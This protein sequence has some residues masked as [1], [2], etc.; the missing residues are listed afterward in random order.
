LVDEKEQG[1]IE[2]GGVKTKFK[3]KVVEEKV[4]PMTHIFV[5][6]LFSTK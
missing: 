2:D 5:V 4:R 1:I 3:V 6:V